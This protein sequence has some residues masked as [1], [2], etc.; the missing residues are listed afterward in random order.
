MNTIIDA[1]DLRRYR[2]ELPNIIDDMGLSVYAFRLYAHIKRVAGAGDG[3]C[4]QSTRR[5]AEICCM[6]VGTAR[7]AKVELVNAGLIV[8]Q[9]NDRTMGEADTIAVVNIGQKN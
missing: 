9:E 2:T 5:M 3:R 7:K 4:F 8:V 1:G 6:S